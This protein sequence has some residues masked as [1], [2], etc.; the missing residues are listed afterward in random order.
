MVQENDPEFDEDDVERAI[1]ASVESAAA[2][3][4]GYTEFE[5]DLRRALLEKVPPVFDALAPAPLSSETVSALPYGAQGVYMLLEKGVPTYIGKTDARH[6]FRQRLHRHLKSLS[7]RSNLNLGDV[8]F[9]AVRVM[10]FTTINVEDVLIDHY[11]KNRNIAWQYSGFGSND[12][13]HLREFQK[14]SEF[15]KKFPID[16]GIP[17]PFIKAGRRNVVQLLSD[18]KSCLPYDLRYETDIGLKHRPVKSH[19]GHCDQRAAWVDITR[20]SMSLREILLLVVRALPDGWVATHF[21]GRVI[22]Y[23]EATPYKEALE[24]ITKS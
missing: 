23:K 22:L 12:P 21:P 14:S 11:I 17:L 15:D 1:D 6:G 4:L 24:Q 8:T 16:I 19:I 7:S 5:L 13:G 2:K 9:K 3:V 18:L 10:V 20:D